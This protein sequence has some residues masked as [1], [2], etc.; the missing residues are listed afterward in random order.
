MKPMPD[1]VRD[2]DA[3][4]AELAKTPRTRL[5]PV[6]RSLLNEVPR[7]ATYGLEVGC[8]D[9][10]VARTLAR[11]G[12]SMI[13]LDASPKMIDVAQSQHDP[14]L[15]IEYRV[16]DVTDVDF[17]PRDFDIVIAINVVHHLP[18]IEIIPRLASLVAPGGVLL[19]QDVVTRDGLLNVPINALATIERIIRRKLTGDENPPAVRNLLNRHGR[20]EIF[21][22]PLQVSPAYRALLPGARVKHQI[23]WRYSVIWKRP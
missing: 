22:S 8:G 18:L 13:A 5:T 2:F 3:V 17:P 1:V 6:E 7:D 11:R 14:K 4:A 15:D 9:G 23:E 20:G 19:I 16:G 10:L 12:V 21:L